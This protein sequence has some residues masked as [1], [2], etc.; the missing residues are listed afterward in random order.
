MGYNPDDVRFFGEIYEKGTNGLIIL[1]TY[2]TT[3]FFWNIPI[4]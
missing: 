1:D 3:I 4:E 2:E